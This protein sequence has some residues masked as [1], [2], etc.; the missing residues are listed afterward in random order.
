[1]SDAPE[2]I[3]HTTDRRGK[4]DTDPD[5]HVK[6]CKA[7]EDSYVEYIRADLSPQWQPIETAPKDGTV[8]LVLMPSI[9]GH[10]KFSDGVKKGY[11]MVDLDEW[12]VEGVGGNVSPQPTR[13]TPIPKPPTE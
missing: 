2:R 11:W 3:W 10:G 9:L 7:V 13:W 12:Q 6:P 5:A 8:V 1:M 4:I